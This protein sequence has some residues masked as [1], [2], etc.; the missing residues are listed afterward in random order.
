MQY[1]ILKKRDDVVL[2]ITNEISC[3][4][5]NYLHSGNDELESGATLLGYRKKNLF[6]VSRIIHGSKVIRGKNYYKNDQVGEQKIFNELRKIDSSI[7]F[8]GIAHTH[9]GNVIPSMKDLMSVA[10]AL[11]YCHDLFIVIMDKLSHNNIAAYYATRK[12]NDLQQVEIIYYEDYAHLT[13]A[14]S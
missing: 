11:K 6:V 13:N 14:P 8:L 1:P 12:D 2:A 4:I 3:E 9:T 10:I 5:N 7:E